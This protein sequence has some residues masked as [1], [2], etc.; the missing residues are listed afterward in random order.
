[1][2]QTFYMENF[3]TIE[4]KLL[5]AFKMAENLVRCKID[6]DGLK[7]LGFW[8]YDLGLKSYSVIK[9][10]RQSGRYSATI[11]MNEKKKI[12]TVLTLTHINLQNHSAQFIRSHNQMNTGNNNTDTI[13]HIRTETNASW[14]QCTLLLITPHYLIDGWTV[15]YQLWPNTA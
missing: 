4:I 7:E 11:R 14:L 10:K 5:E 15:S 9:V 13:T 1:M 8:F 6:A 3:V 2:E 12:V